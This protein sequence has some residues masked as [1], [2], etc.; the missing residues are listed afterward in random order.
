MQ[1]KFLYGCLGVFVIGLIVSGFLLVYGW[2]EKEGVKKSLQTI[3]LEGPLGD[4]LIP[5][6]E[7]EVAANYLIKDW[8]K[9]DYITVEPPTW[10]FMALVA[11]MLLVQVGYWVF[12]FLN[13]ATKWED[14]FA[15]SVHGRF[16][17]TS[18]YERNYR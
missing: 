6:I 11:A 17:K 12:A 16:R 2:T 9:F 3:L 7:R 5:K 4:E 13:E 14:T 15:G 10:S 8:S 1:N 18:F